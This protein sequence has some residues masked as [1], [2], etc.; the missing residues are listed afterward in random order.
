KA[1][2]PGADNVQRELEL[3]LDL[4][5]GRASRHA[6]A[7]HGALRSGAAAAVA[8]DDQR[9]R[10][11][12]LLTAAAT[13]AG[14][15]ELLVELERH[16]TWLG[17]SGTLSRRRR[18]RLAQRTRDVVDRAMRR[19]VWQESRADDLIAARLD[20]VAAGGISPYQLAAEVVATLKEGARV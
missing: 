11:P 16:W 20:D 15:D 3:A 19:W 17:E 4:R 10:P 5:M 2:R 6:A 7:H 8:V 12:V 9:W 13:D 18:E 1:D 14:V